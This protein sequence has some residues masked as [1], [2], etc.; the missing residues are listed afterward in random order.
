MFNECFELLQENH[1]DTKSK[2]FN[3]DFPVFLEAPKTEFILSLKFS[4][5]KHT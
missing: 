4:N 5:S 1:K 3:G 2:K